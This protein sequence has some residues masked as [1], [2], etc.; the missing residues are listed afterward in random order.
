MKKNKGNVKAQRERRK[1]RAKMY[2]HVEQ[3]EAEILIDGNYSTRAVAFCA[4][5]NGYLTYPLIN[6]HGCIERKCDKLVDERMAK[7]D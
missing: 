6:T 7:H 3:G 5:Y 2:P 1:E 4:R